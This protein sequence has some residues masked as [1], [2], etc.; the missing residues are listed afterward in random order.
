M[1]TALL[2]AGLLAAAEPVPRVMRLD[3]FH[4]GNAA[5]ERFALDGVTLEGAWPGHPGRMFDNT[6]LGKYN[7]EIIDTKTG[8][9]LFSRGFASIFGEWRN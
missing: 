2:L 1:L 8:R 6:N 3:Y 4:T 5:E 7:F 9:V